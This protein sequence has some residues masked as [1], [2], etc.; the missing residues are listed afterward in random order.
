MS[1]RTKIVLIVTT[2]LILLILALFATYLIFTNFSTGIPSGE[3]ALHYDGKDFPLISE[4]AEQMKKIFRFKF[5]DFGI[6]GCP[7]EEDIS[8]TFG[9][10]VFAI[11]TDGCY[12]AK[13]WDAERYIV[14]SRSEFEQ[15]AALFKKYC[16]NTP[17]YLYC[18]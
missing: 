11:A 10:T 3:A 17:I 16:G 14:F 9:D 18:P 15:I 8:I 12:S 13:E 7:Y 6:G 5:Y 4:E 2:L 1:R